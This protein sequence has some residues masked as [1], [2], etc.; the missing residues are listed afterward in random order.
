[1]HKILRGRCYSGYHFNIRKVYLEGLCLN[2]NSVLLYRVR[3]SK[4]ITISRIIKICRKSDGQ[5]RY[6]LPIKLEIIKE[7]SLAPPCELEIEILGKKPR[8]YK[9]DPLSIKNKVDGVSLIEGKA[10]TCIPYGNKLFLFKQGEGR[11]GSSIISVPRFIVID[12]FLLWNMGFYLAEGLKK[13]EHRI[14][15]SNSEWYLIKRF[16]VFI[17]DYLGI[18]EKYIY[19][20][21]RLNE[22]EKKARA[23]RFWSEK[24][25]LKKHQLRTS[26]TN[27]RPPKAEHGNAELVIYNTALSHMFMS[28]FKRVL[29]LKLNREG[30]L[31]LIRGIEAGDG[32]IMEH[33]GIEIGVVSDKKYSGII[34]NLF[35]QICPEIRIRNHHTSENAKIIFC[36]GR[37]IALSFLFDDHFIEHKKRRARLIE[38]LR[39][40][41]RKD[42]KYMKL[43]Q[44]S[45][46]VRGVSRKGCVTFRAANMMLKRLE[47]DGFIRKTHIHVKGKRAERMYKTR[48]FELT[49]M[50][51]KLLK[52]LYV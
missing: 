25:N 50:G 1:M 47:N 9:P 12:N 28:L 34:L 14:S 51:D 26:K 29:T 16:L 31:N 32:Y 38:L 13:N 37:R 43:V 35:S 11:G 48:A 44:S 4:L 30:V 46:T 19:L 22:E 17:K 52:Y 7:L 49:E 33:S 40:Y 10:F 15:V 21:I 45:K 39:Y 18:E 36:K 42:I 41:L 23:I 8:G 27:V 24:L 6:I 5:I 20:Q 2:E 3:N